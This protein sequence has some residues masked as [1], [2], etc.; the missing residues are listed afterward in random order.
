MTMP[1]IDPTHITRLKPKPNTC[2]IIGYQS[3]LLKD[4]LSGTSVESE[5][6]LDSALTPLAKIS[7]IIPETCKKRKT[8]FRRKTKT[9]ASFRGRTPLYN[10]LSRD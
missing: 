9:G 10:L 2:S 8:S 7:R 6:N 5:E 3:P 1:T 4:F